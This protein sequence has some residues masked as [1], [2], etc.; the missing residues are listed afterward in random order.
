MR[1]HWRTALFKDIM[2]WNHTEYDLFKMEDTAGKK[3]IRYELSRNTYELK[4]TKFLKI[5]RLGFW[6]SPSGSVGAKITLNFYDSLHRFTSRTKRYI[7]NSEGLIISNVRGFFLACI[8]S[9][10]NPYIGMLQLFISVVPSLHMPRHK[11]L[12]PWHGRQNRKSA[13]KNTG[14]VTFFTKCYDGV[15]R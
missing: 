5:T 6:N 11:L 1:G 3:L 7:C 4:N 2:K 8:S 15:I 10:T 12:S 9:L 13:T 14:T